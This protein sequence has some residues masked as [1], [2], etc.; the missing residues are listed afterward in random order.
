MVN[1][2]QEKAGKK[3]ISVSLDTN[4]E[5]LF[6]EDCIV[7]NKDQLR[8]YS[9]YCTHLGCRIQQFENGHLICPCHGSVFDLDGNPLKGPAMKPLRKFEYKFNPDTNTLTIN[10]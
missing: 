4:R 5:V 3:T 1:K 2:E 9:S 10:V 6:L 8:V 7:I